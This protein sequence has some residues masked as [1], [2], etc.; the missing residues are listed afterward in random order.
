MCSPVSGEADAGVRR[1]AERV[2]A[3]RVDLRETRA[4]RGRVAA[5]AFVDPVEHEDVV[6]GAEDLGHAQAARLGQPAQTHRLG[7]VLAGRDTHPRLDERE[8]LVRELHAEGVVDVP[9]ADALEVPQVPA[10]GRADCVGDV[11]RS[12]SRRPRQAASTWSST[13]SKPSGPP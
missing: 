5:A 4:E 2:G 3:R 12:E 13:C 7:R 1:C 9:A 8:R 11:H 6:A 10:R